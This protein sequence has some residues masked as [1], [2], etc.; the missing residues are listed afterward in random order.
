M[1]QLTFLDP[2]NPSIIHSPALVQFI[3]MPLG[4]CD[5]ILQALGFDPLGL[6]YTD[7]K[8]RYRQFSTYLVENSEPF[9]LSLFTGLADDT[10]IKAMDW[11]QCGRVLGAIAC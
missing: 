7:K 8:L 9:G 11:G 10:V 5:A 6:A 4:Q 1:T 2:L 3:E